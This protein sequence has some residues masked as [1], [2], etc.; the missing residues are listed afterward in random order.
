MGVLGVYD[1]AELPKDG[2]LGVKELKLELV[3]T[4]RARLE[5][6]RLEAPAVEG[7]GVEDVEDVARAPR[8][9]FDLGGEQQGGLGD[10]AHV[11]LLHALA[12]VEAVEDDLARCH[13]RLV[14]AEE[15]AGLLRFFGGMSL[16]GGGGW[17]WGWWREGGAR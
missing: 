9:L 17:W 11:A 13:G 8:L 3:V 6:G 1:K 4:R 2:S 15:D 7:G 5:R 14:D 10:D 12:E 16:G